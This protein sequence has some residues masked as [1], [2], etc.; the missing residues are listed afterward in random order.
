MRGGVADFPGGCLHNPVPGCS[1][2]GPGVAL[3]GWGKGAGWAPR[4]GADWSGALW[5]GFSAIQKQ[6]HL[7]EGPASEQVIT[8]K[9]IF[10]VY[11]INN[12]REVNSPVYSIF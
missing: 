2:C 12:W 7:Q 5:G 1:R 10:T 3:G 8:Q 9:S 11:S 4:K 6:S